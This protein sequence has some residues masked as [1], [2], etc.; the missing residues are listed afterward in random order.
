MDDREHI[1]RELV[2][3]PVLAHATF[4]KESHSDHTPNFHKVIIN[5]WHSQLP[6]VLDLA[7][8]GAAKST[9]AEEAIT[10]MAALGETRNCIIIGESYERA[11]DRLRAI[12]HH[13]ETNDFIQATLGV[14]PGPIWTEDKIVLNNNS[15]I[16][17]F[18]RGQSLRGVKYINERPD[19]AFYDDLED[20]D[21]VATPE[22][23]KKTLQWFTGTAMP[24]LAMPVRRQRMAATPLHPEA[25]AVVLSRNDKWLTRVYPVIYKSPSTGEWVATWPER[26]SV[27]W[28]LELWAHMTALGQEEDFVQ[29]YLCQASDP[30]SQTFTDGMFKIV[31][32]KRSWHS[33]YAIYDPARTTNKSSATTGKVVASWIG[34]KLV[35]WESSATKLMPDAIIE[36]IF[37]T[38]EQYSPVA[39]GFEEDGLNEWA[40]QPIR[41]EQLRRGV[42]LPLRPLKAPRNKI[43]FIRG[44]QPYFKSGEVEFTQ[45]FPELQNQL[46]GFPKGHI[47]APNALAY[48]LKLKLGSPIYDGL[49]DE[50][51]VDKIK[52]LKHNPINISIN[53]DGKVT[54]AQ[55]I[56]YTNRRLMILKDWL[57]EADPGEALQD[58]LRELNLDLPSNTFTPRYFAP[59]KHFTEYNVLGLRA[60]ALKA[61]V[62][63]SRGGDPMVGRE[64]IRALMRRYARDLP[65][66]IISSQAR[67]TL[68]ALAGGYARDVT[69][70][71]PIY[72]AYAVLMDGLE[73][74]VGL[75]RGPEAQDDKDTNFAYTA[76]G[77]RYISA[78]GVAR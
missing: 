39:I 2:S 17:A 58:I 59:R 23:R 24:A 1:I 72:N 44:L 70:D 61:R 66:F 9:L 51:V 36:D 22:S 20:K 38:D 54:T 21:S 4:F 68:R 71:H 5:D 34:R 60:A 77:R 14:E 15:I 57:V 47:D 29:E 28:S 3:D 48:M 27:Q 52:P 11:V 78:L 13:I 74:L 19:L 55:L 33:V 31:P 76:D 10:V 75:M 63:I 45:P 50:H 35:V 49:N 12:K 62:N 73:S 42:V 32:R 6:N 64:E 53:T 25:L 18:G 26:F 30:S 69:E 43:D 16:Q 8:R 65:A 46:I 67:W 40:L 37:R 7:F 41:S 56:Q